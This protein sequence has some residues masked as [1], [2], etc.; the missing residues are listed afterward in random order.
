MPEVPEGEVNVRETVKQG[1]D[2]YVA[3]EEGKHP[4]LAHLSDKDQ[5]MIVDLRQEAAGNRVKAKEFE[6]KLSEL[7]EENRK[8]NEA[9]LKKQGKLEELLS[10]KENEISE[11]KPLQ[12]KVSGYEKY[13]QEQLDAALE[14]LTE[15]QREFI[16]DSD[17]DLQKKWKWAT[18][19]KSEGVAPVAP[20]P[21]SVRPGGQAPSE[22]F[23]IADYKG[24]DGVKKLA[25]L[26][27]TNP[28][29]FEAI[30]KEKNKNLN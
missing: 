26:K 8:R 11:L 30:L 10:A 21:D 28:N 13:F 22:G 9:E 14:Q 2:T 25:A 23:D 17:M 18:K 27:Y 19:L 5:Q 1:E 3:P 20:P 15:I 16:N 4:G 29:L 7:M 12:D 24:P 6:S